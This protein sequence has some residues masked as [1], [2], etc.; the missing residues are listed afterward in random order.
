MTENHLKV[1]RM[2]LPALQKLVW[3][4]LDSELASLLGLH[5]AVGMSMQTCLDCNVTLL[6]AG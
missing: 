2:R 1:V 4:V 6:L 3:Q 5:A